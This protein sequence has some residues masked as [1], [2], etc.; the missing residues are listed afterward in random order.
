[1]LLV[2]GIH[3]VFDNRPDDEIDA[4]VYTLFAHLEKQVSNGTIQFYGV[5]S[6]HLCEPPKRVYPPLP[7]DANVADC[8]KNPKPHPPVV[9][10]RR[11]IRIA[12][13]VGGEEHHFRFVEYPMNLTEHQAMSRPLPYEPGHTLQSL[14]KELG[15]TTL[16]V[17]PIETT[18]LCF[19]TQRYH[20]YPMDSDLKN[21]RVQ[22][23]A[24]TEKGI[25]KELEV[26][27]AYVKAQDSLPPLG[28]VFLATAFVTTMRQIVNVHQFADWVDKKL[29]PSFRRAIYR[30]REASGREMKDWCQEYEN[31]CYDIFRLRRRLLDHRHGKRAHEINN[32]VDQSSPALAKCPMINQ[33]AINFATHG[34]DVVV[35][36]FHV[37]RYFH[38]ATELN[39]AKNGKLALPVEELRALCENKTVTFANENPPHPYQLDIPL[40]GTISRRKLRGDIISV[41]PANPKFPD[42]HDEIREGEGNV[43]P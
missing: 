22:L 12:E 21:S 38:E 31:V 10:L 13:R 37:A 16:G 23:Y 24:A 26:Y 6:P 2:E 4:E 18:D 33:K 7:P 41:D 40:A 43:K 5:S 30:V 32:A 17:R 1:V 11:L 34:A 9:N 28:E 36:G 14:C 20:N 35:S 27:E 15:I 3:V 8:F 25:Q 29:M 42:I 39:P 19:Q